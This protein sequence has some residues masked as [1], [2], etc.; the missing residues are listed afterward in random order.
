MNPSFNDALYNPDTMIDVPLDVD[1][2]Q[3]IDSLAAGVEVDSN[4][5]EDTKELY[6]SKVDILIQLFL[7]PVCPFILLTLL[8]LVIG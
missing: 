4:E 5:V 6:K 8:Y 3:A 1:P 7:P 2:C